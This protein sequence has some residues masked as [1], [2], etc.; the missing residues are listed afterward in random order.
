MRN[1]GPDE[2]RQYA[3]TRTRD[4]N[5][6]EDSGRSSGLFRSLK[7]EMEVAAVAFMMP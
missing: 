6:L 2:Q 5:Y 4:F 7:L 3:V 1:E